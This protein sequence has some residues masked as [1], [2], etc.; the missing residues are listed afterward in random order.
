MKLENK[1]II[2]EDDKHM[3]KLFVICGHGAGDSG[4]CGNGYQE[5]ERVRVLGKRIKELGGDNV[6]LG[7]VNR[8]FYADK[9]IS[10]LTIS[11]DYQ[12][13]ELHMDSSA[14]QSAKGAHVII[15]GAYEPDKY[16]QAL[17]N[18]FA[19]LF[20]GRSKKISQRTDLQNP[21]MAANKGYGYRLIECGFIS[22]AGDVSIFNNNIDNMAK[23]IL[24]VFGIPVVNNSRPE[25]KPA[26]KPSS[27]PNP[28]RSTGA[29]FT[30]T[31]LWTQANGGKW[32]PASQLIYGK[33]DYKIGNVHSGA[34]HPYEAVVNGA[35]IGFANDKC[36][37]DEPSLP[38][39]KTPTLPKPST[40]VI[41]VGAKVTLK[42]SASRYATGELIPAGYKGKTYTIMQVGSGKVLLK[43]LYSW[44]YTKDI[45]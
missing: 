9:G 38:S 5:Q 8:N 30:C 17:A 2:R 36:I 19:G 23:N 11:K 39:G 28:N 3:S 18:F 22:N 44:V 7:D 21:A 33:G 37:D 29:L 13:V 34:E 25:N 20:P 45:A 1:N 15:W 40:P 31:G 12:I 10:N 32:Y 26:N 42:T 27:K 43:E 6:M 35:I 14:A 41:K 4:A 16:D 24:S